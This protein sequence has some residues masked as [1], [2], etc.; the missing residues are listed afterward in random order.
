MNITER[1]AED[2]RFIIE[3]AELNLNQSQ[4]AHG[5]PAF[6][7]ILE[8]INRSKGLFVDSRASHQE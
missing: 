2:I 5:D 1:Q 6:K 7:P 8:A 4:F 3:Y